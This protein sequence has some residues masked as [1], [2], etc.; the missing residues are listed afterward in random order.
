[1]RQRP[2]KPREPKLAARA[3][4]LHYSS[5]EAPGIH[6]KGAPGCFRYV[7]PN[8][9]P[10]RDAPTLKR[11][12]ELVIP[13]AWR[14]VWIA[15]DP[16]AHLQATGR[17]AR[18]RKQY[19]YHPA[20]A[21][22]RDA[23]KYDHLLAF[24][25]ALPALH[26]RLARDMRKKGLPRERVLACAITLLEES[27]IRVGNESYARQNHSYGLATLANRHVR[28]HGGTLRFLFTG[29]SGKRWDLAIHDRRV[30]RILRACQELPGQHL[31]EYRDGDGGIH[32]V[33]SGDVNTYLREVTGA[34]VTA[35]DF[36][37]WA[38][39]MMAAAAFAR[40]KGP[41]TKK[42]AREVVSGVAGRLGNTVAV[43]RKCYIHPSIFEAFDR[44]RLKLA[45]R[46]NRRVT[47]LSAA[48]KAV[49]KLL[50]G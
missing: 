1:M 8:G 48:E 13:P 19:R 14:D 49:L 20:F 11:I 34:D 40:L 25:K 37:T 47:G 26:R 39:T 12:R 18:G 46:N 15:A 24:A 7:R 9:R 33:T 17:D 32:A 28:I 23:D 35:K 42:A 44:G 31:L 38:G 21:A 5:D 43:C 50:K 22:V 29:K 10:V 4:G 36:R 6:R 30:A 16:K 41:V 45:S 27:L 3:A 2:V